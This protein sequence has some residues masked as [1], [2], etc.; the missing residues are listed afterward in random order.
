[1][2]DGSLLQTHMF[3]DSRYPAHQL[4]EASSQ[5]GGEG[6]ATLRGIE[7]EQKKS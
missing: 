3:L 5:T 7:S 4:E 6:H 2:D 1:M